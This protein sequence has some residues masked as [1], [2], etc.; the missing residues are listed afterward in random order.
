[1]AF[2]IL[3]S[4]SV[5]R[6]TFQGIKKCASAAGEGHLSGGEVVAKKIKSAGIEENGKGFKKPS[7][8]A[9][10]AMRKK[11]F[12]ELD[13]STEEIEVLQSELMESIIIDGKPEMW[14]GNGERAR[15]FLPDSIPPLIQGAFYCIRDEICDGV[16]SLEQIVEGRAVLFV[17]KN[18]ITGAKTTY[19]PLSIRDLAVGNSFIR[20]VSPEEAEEYKNGY[21]R[22][23]ILGALG[24]QKERRRKRSGERGVF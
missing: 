1:M 14:G 12:A 9:I 5:L 21:F 8:K 23:H 13:K 18:D 15:Y 3:L 10:R 4:V 20:P 19:T 17:F 22:S 24:S 6:H 16:F 11:T 2:L 7:S